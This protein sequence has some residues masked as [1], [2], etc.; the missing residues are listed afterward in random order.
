M[1]KT[2]KK[3]SFFPLPPAPSPGYPQ[4]PNP[5]PHEDFGPDPDPDPQKKCGSETLIYVSIYPSL[6][7]F[8][9]V[10]YRVYQKS[11]T[12]EFPTLICA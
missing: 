8:I 9:Y 10:T 2:Q 12:N 6:S 7:I 3:N 1:I 11:G 4:D 5:D